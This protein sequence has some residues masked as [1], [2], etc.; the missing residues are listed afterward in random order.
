MFHVKHLFCFRFIT[1]PVQLLLVWQASKNATALISLYHTFLGFW[2]LDITLFEGFWSDISHFYAIAKNAQL[3][4]E[5]ER[6]E[7]LKALG[8]FGGAVFENEDSLYTGGLFHK[9]KRLL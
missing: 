3:V 6:A 8:G 5:L 1:S 4:G 9:A 7:T 2:G